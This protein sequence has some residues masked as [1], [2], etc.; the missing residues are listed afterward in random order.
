MCK[1][2]ESADI[3]PADWVL[4]VGCGGGSLTSIVAG[5]A[6]QVIAVDI[7]PA[8]IAIATEQLA[9]RPNV[10]IVH[11]DALARKSALADDVIAKMRETRRAS[12]GRGLLVANLP[13][14]IATSLVANLLIGDFGI[15]RM[16]FSVQSEVADRFLAH[17]ETPDYGP[18]SVIAQTFAVVS[19][20]ARVPPQAFWPSPKV[21]SSMVRLEAR[22]DDEIIV[23]D[24]A[25]FSG[26]LREAFR[27]RRK[28][29]GHIFHR[30]P[31][32]EQ[33]V[34]TLSD[35]GLSPQARP[36]EVAAEGWQTLFLAI[37]DAEAAGSRQ[38]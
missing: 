1:L 13:Y 10:T 8:M 21:H 7:D 31:G 11:T 30:M 35:I 29:L 6:G 9:N 33:L 15:S 32:G 38:H 26:F 4:E 3:G 14:D 23:R 19:R 2:V 25:G 24:R 17:P 20:I 36:A 16:C 22:G 5:L 34:A 37:H 28:T 12:S 18:V 27:S